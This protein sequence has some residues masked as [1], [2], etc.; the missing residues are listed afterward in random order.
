[1]TLLFLSLLLPVLVV[2]KQ[3]KGDRN[4]VPVLSQGS[5][6]TVESGEHI[7]HAAVLVKCEQMRTSVATC[8]RLLNNLNTLVC[9]DIL[10]HM[11]YKRRAAGP[12]LSAEPLRPILSHFLG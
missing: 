6:A 1:M 12:A 9:E 8:L 5:A 11:L 7:L 4:N 3:T 2:S 10:A